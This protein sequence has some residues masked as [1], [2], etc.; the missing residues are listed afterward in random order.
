LEE[1]ALPVPLFGEREGV[2]AFASR[3]HLL[4]QLFEV[5]L[6]GLLVG[7]RLLGALREVP[8]DLFVERDLLRDDA[9]G[10]RQLVGRIDEA[11]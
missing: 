4:A 1:R 10:Q 6:E 11:R 3:H 8:T 7:A 5:L 2:L 9:I